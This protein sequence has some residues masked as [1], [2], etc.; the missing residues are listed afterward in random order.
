MAAMAVQARHLGLMIDAA[1]LS[2]EKHGILAFRVGLPVKRPFCV[3][4]V[5]TRYPVCSSLLFGVLDAPFVQP[6]R[7]QRWLLVPVLHDWIIPQTLQLTSVPRTY[8]TKSL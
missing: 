1:K 4:A 8:T 2:G 6:T 5:S 7:D 3:S